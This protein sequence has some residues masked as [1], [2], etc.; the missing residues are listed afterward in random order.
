VGAFFCKGGHFL[1]TVGTFFGK[2]GP[3]LGTGG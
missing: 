1:A 3:F 2:V